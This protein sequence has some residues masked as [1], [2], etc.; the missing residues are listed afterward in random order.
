MKNKIMCS[1]NSC[2]ESL[3]LLVCSVSACVY[4]GQHRLMT[5]AY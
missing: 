4:V 1:S 2:G 5:W 3:Q